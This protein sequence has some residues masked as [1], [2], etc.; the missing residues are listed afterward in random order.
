MASLVNQIEQAVGGFDLGASAG[1]LGAQLGA[2]QQAIAGLGQVPAFT[3]ALSGLG[4]VQAP[5][6]NFGASLGS[7]L[8]GLLPAFQGDLGGVVGQLQGD[9][10]ALPDRLRSELEGAL[11]PLLARIETLRSLLTEDWSCGLVPAMAPPAPAPAP[12]PAPSPA[13]APAPAAPASALSPQQVTDAKTVVDRLPADLS[14]PGLLRWVHE[15]VG[16]TRP[17]YF[18]VRSL[19]LIDDIRDPLDTLLRWEAASAADVQTE[20]GQ[21]LASLTALV[22]AHTS[23]RF[24]AALAPAAALPAAT[25]GTAAAAYADAL[26][27]LDTAVQAADAAALPAALAAAQTALVPLLAANTALAGTDAPLNT[28]LRALPPALDA[29]IARLL[30]LLQ[31]RPSLGDLADAIG[32]FDTPVLPPAALAPL[33]NALTRLQQQLTAVLDAVDIGSVTQPI[34]EALASVEA[35]VQAI[36]QALAQ[37]SAQALQLIAQAR[38]A[39]QAIDLAAL[40]TEGEQALNGVVG[41]LTSGIG[42]TLATATTSLTEVL[43]TLDSALD[44]IDPEALTEPVREAIAALGDL[45]QQEAVQR[46]AE[47]AGQIEELA[48]LIAQLGFEPVA[49]QVIALIEELQA[50]IAGIDLSSLPD[51]G[52]ALLDEAMGL[53]PPSLQPLADPLVTELDTLLAGSPIA[54]LEQVKALPEVV[55][56]RLFAFSP[57]QALQPLILPPYQAALGGLTDFS[58]ASWFTAGDQAFEQLRQRLARELDPAPLMAEPSRV[59]NSLVAELEG[60]QPS[61]LLAPLEQAVE[62]ALQQVGAALP[63]GDLAAALQAVLDRIRAFTSTVTAALE[64]A[65]HFTDKL[66]A[67]GDAPAEF[68]AWLATVLAKVPTTATGALATAVAD[69]R[70]AALAA[71]PDALAATWLAAHSGLSTALQTADAAALLARITGARSRIQAGAA[72]PAVAA[73]VPGLAAWIAADDTRRAGDGLVALGGVSRSLDEAQA[74]LAAQFTS[75]AAAFPGAEGPLGA[76]VPAGPATL[77]SWVDTA[78]RRQLG[79]PLLGLL[80]ALQPLVLMLQAASTALGTLAQA[81]DQKVDDLL[82]A[83]QALA[84]LL[85][86]VDG[87]AQR[88]AGLDLGLYTREIDTVHAELLD[89]VRALDPRHLVA[90]LVEARDALLATLSMQALVPPALRGQL[91]TL[92]RTLLAKLAA[93][94][95]DALLLEPLDAEYREL[96]EP[97]AEALDISASVQLLIDWLQALPE[98]LR[99]QLVRVDGAYGKLLRSAPGG[100]PAGSGVALAL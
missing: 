76:L 36:E 75:L 83:P 9:V 29:G 49:D 66:A 69:L 11:S 7:G 18:T 46:V 44:D 28:S 100:A 78:V 22:Q 27:T 3:Q 97:L 33:T 65:E 45:A 5:S 16:T 67:L 14:V 23:G 15:R 12:A 89:Q 79:V 41:N 57:R 87:L 38:D 52:P 74:A 70:A 32:P 59:F 30:V 85:G 17:G 94:D 84:D 31:P 82:A 42:N 53:L 50:L 54:L 10:A 48:A 98:D 35:A 90:P 13:P 96:V 86:S 37:L 63:V 71:H 40:R 72:A 62:Q 91:D 95:P 55:R 58:P 24:T 80:G 81:I 39:V 34:T 88:I 93:L 56:E 25:L 47:L 61:T 1:P 92:H 60:L 51:P 20:L 43:G 99:A 77:R 73:A 26:D 21:T 64:I 8:Q 68:D 4:A 19:P 6:L 2:V